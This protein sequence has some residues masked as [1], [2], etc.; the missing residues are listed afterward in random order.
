[1]EG[2]QGSWLRRASQKEPEPAAEQHDGDCDEGHGQNPERQ[3]RRTPANGRYEAFRSPTELD[4]RIGGGEGE[5]LSTI[6]AWADD[7]SDLPN[8]P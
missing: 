5:E 3:S 8:R 1:V 2:E 6:Q 7:E 4:E